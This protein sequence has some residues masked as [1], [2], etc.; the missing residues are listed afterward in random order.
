M[1]DSTSPHPIEKALTGIDGFDEIS[2][3]G[4]PAGRATLLVGGPGAGKTLFALQTLVQGAKRNEPGIFVAFEEGGE[5]ILQNTASFGWELPRLVAENKLL[6]FDA[7][8]SSEAVR[9]GAFDLSGLLSILEAKARAMGAGMIAFD[10]MDVLLTL[11][12]DPAAE[13][14]E[15]Y[16]IR[17]WLAATGLTGIL[18]IR[19]AGIAERLEDRYAF[20]QFM[21]DCLISLETRLE[22]QALIRQIRIVKY[23]GSGY[24]QNAFPMIVGPKGIEVSSFGISQ[25]AYPAPATRVSTGIDALDRMLEGGY[26]RGSGVLVTGGPGTA[27]TTLSGAFANATCAGGQRV[28]YFSFDEMPDEIIRNLASVGLRLDPHVES[29]ALKMYWA[30]TE[31]RSVEEHLLRINQML[32]EFKPDAAIVDPMSALVRAGGPSAALKVSQRLIHF[33]KTNGVTLLL[34]NLLEHLEAVNEENRIRLSTLID[35]W[36]H[37]N[38]YINAGERNRGLTIMKARGTAHSAQMRELILS[39]HGLSLAP[40]YTIG[41][42]VYMGTL[43]EQ[44]EAAEE[45]EGEQL[46]GR[47]KLKRLEMEAAEAEINQRIKAMQLDLESRRAEADLLAREEQMRQETLRKRLADRAK[48]AGKNGSEPTGK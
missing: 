8:L 1:A 33:A 17:E 36:I 28:L 2:G 14:E 11:L 35:T 25:G 5:Q 6:I 41:N 19:F 37:L 10:A 12:N 16:R 29:G 26:F 23:R 15:V 24:E 47:A 20:V 9:A 48:L 39:R 44:K 27:K 31:A 30:R 46:R 34:T 40:V 45:L 42:E 22:E 4:L 13:R 18:S 38:F 32:A 3:G 21:A 43:R 7:R